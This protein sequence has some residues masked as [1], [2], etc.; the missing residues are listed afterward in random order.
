MQQFI[1]VEAKRDSRIKSDLDNF[2]NRYVDKNS[3]TVVIYPGFQITTVYKHFY[4]LLSQS[5]RV[6]FTHKWNMRPDYT[7]FDHYGTT[8]YW[9]LILYINSVDCI[10]DFYNLESI[11][12]P[13]LKSILSLVS[14]RVPRDDIDSP[15]SK[16]KAPKYYKRYPMDDIESTRNQSIIDLEKLITPPSPECVIKEKTDNFTLTSTDTTLM[17]VDLTYPV[18]NYSSIVFQIEGYSTIQTYAYDYIVTTDDNNKLRRIIW[19][20]DDCPLGNGMSHLIESG[21]II[22]ITYAYAE[23]GCEPCDTSQFNCISGGQI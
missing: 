23:I 1:D 18:I 20:G 21:D 5:K 10:E 16:N 9:W 13:S 12:I 22:H 14:D 4:Y 15:S 17:Y 8:V 7:S 2:R 3:T 6:D 11:Y 19:D